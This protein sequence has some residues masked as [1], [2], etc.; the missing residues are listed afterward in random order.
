MY[1]DLRVKITNLVMMLIAATLSQLLTEFALYYRSTTEDN[2][3][4]KRR[5]P[6]PKPTG[7]I[8][9]LLMLPEQTRAL[10]DE[11]LNR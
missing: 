6:P 3:P 5:H 1:R 2:A 7:I 11:F 9:G 8:T 10:V 4:R